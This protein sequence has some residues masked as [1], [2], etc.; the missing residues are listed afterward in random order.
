M[1]DSEKPKRLYFKTFLQLVN[2]SVGSEMFRNFYVSTEQ[3]GEFDALGD[4]E[5]SCAF[6]VSSVLVLF[7]KAACVHG[8]IN[9]TLDDI[10]KSGWQEVAEPKAGDILVWESQDFGDEPK[11]HIGF[12]IGGDKAVSTSRSSKKVAE[13]HKNFDGSRKIE[14]I[15][16][17]A[18]WDD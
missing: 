12:Y 5:N 15:F 4:G 10:K 17:M 7:K 8:T 3:Q 18:S 9:S 2:N 14:R 1:T 6:F 13:H 16:R 11:R